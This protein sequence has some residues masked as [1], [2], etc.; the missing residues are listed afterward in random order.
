MSLKRNRYSGSNIHD[1]PT[2]KRGTQKSAYDESDDE[3]L[4]IGDEEYPIRCII[5]ET[6]TKY[7]IDWEGDYPPSWVRSRRRIP[8][9]LLH[10]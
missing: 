5:A 9:A 2:K 1:N 4:D 3:S 7:L 10:N 8:F 6:R